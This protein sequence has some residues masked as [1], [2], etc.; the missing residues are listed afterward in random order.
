MTKQL[1]EPES[2]RP[3][4]TE[5]LASVI[6]GGFFSD[7]ADGARFLAV[8]MT[9]ELLKTVGATETGQAWV[10]DAYNSFPKR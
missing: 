4:S 7:I 6:G 5:E 9:G 1:P 10:D 3:L 8:G 2:L